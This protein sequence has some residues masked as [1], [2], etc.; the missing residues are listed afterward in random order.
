MCCMYQYVIEWFCVKRKNM[1]DERDTNVIS[2]NLYVNMMIDIHAIACTYD[3]VYIEFH[4]Q[5]ASFLFCGDMNSSNIGC[6]CWILSNKRKNT[7]NII[8]F[9]SDIFRES[10]QIHMSRKLFNFI[11]SSIIAFLFSE[12]GSY[13]H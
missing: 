10:R 1:F 4:M 7:N 5:C 12:Y 3:T 2:F 11:L 13:L 8:W 6:E 9:P